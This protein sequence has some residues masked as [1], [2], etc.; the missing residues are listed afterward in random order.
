[1]ITRSGLLTRRSSELARRFGTLYLLIRSRQHRRFALHV[2]LV[3]SGCVGRS[4]AREVPEHRV[5]VCE[6]WCSV[7]VDPVCGSKDVEEP[8]ECVDR[9]T[10]DDASWAPTDDGVDRCASEAIEYVDC[11][12]Q[13]TCEQQAAHFANDGLIGLPG[14]EDPCGAE[15]RSS[16]ECAPARD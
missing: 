9:C 7:I 5:D 11:I 13:L 6:R 1:M 8:D 15:L 14:S 10:H 4:T 3:I 12:E 16:L 2:A